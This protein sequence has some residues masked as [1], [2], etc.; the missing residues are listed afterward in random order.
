MEGLVD[1]RAFL[2]WL[3]QQMSTC[4]LAQ[5]GFVAHLA[6]EYLD[7]MLPNRALAKAFIDACIAKLTEVRNM[8]FCRQYLF[9]SF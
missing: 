9:S 8:I 4:N 3:V 1:S 6:D 5:T 7:D 2:T